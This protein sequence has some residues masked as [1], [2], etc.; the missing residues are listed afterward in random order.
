MKENEQLLRNTH[1]SPRLDN[2]HNIL[3]LDVFY[4]DETPLQ[5]LSIHL[6]EENQLF[7]AR[8]TSKSCI[9]LKKI[10][11][12]FLASTIFLPFLAVESKTSGGKGQVVTFLRQFFL[13]TKW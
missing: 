6:Q 8:L 4:N 2:V 1:Q 3:T 7:A 10:L 11:F 12:S 5:S 13:E 9:T